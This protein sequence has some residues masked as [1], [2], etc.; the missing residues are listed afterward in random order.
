MRH[1]GIGSKLRQKQT[2]CEVVVRSMNTWDLPGGPV[3]NNPPSSAG[4]TG[5]IPDQ[6]A[7]ILHTSEQLS[8]K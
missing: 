4:D 6:G 2:C 8:L 7:K 5:L 1:P 3:V